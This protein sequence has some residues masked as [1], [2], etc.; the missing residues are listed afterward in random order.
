MS[1][2]KKP[3]AV[4][5]D[6]LD[7]DTEIPGQRYV[8][9]SFLSPENVLDKKELFF[10]EKFLQ[11][12]EVDWKVKNLEKYMVDVVKNI[13][14]QLDDRIRE[15]EKNEQNDQAEICRKN[16]VNITSLMTEYEGFIK[17]QKQDLNKTKIVDS[18][19]DFLYMNQTK[20]ED[21]FYALNDFRTS[22][23]GLKVRG[24]SGNAKEAEIRAKKLQGKDKYHNIFIGEVGKWLPWDPSPPQIAEQEYAQD[25]LNNLMKKY[26]QN[27]D[28]K[29]KFFEERSKGSKKQVFGA[30][31]ESV[32]D[33]FDG[34]FGQGGD[35]AISRKLEKPTV[36]IERVDEAN[37]E[38]TTEATTEITN[39]V[40]EPS[41]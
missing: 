39:E 5:E 41:A 27:E 17:K 15:L 4:V 40:I 7:E 32:S 34:M 3:V 20:L 19:N 29:E 35:L 16:R 2:D 6:F 24:V 37:T 38:V 36:T 21:E 8:L 13:N 18:Y 26:R 22:M 12:H 33:Q 28:D 14:D 11:N 1:S 31:S 30:G 25:Q 9:L 23:R 10:F